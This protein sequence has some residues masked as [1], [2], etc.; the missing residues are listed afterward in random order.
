MKNFMKNS[1]FEKKTYLKLNFYE[2]D[3]YTYNICNVSS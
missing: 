2:K 3:I 1:T